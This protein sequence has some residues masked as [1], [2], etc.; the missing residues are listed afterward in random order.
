MTLEMTSMTRQEA[1]AIAA[2]RNLREEVF[3]EMKTSSPTE[4]L[5]KFNILPDSTTREWYIDSNYNFYYM[6]HHEALSESKTLLPLYKAIFSIDN[7]E[8]IIRAFHKK[9]GILIHIK[10]VDPSFTYCSFIQ[11]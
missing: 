4:A 10:E 3:N 11:Y 9:T 2:I 7:A 5:R 1:L 6:S 8:E